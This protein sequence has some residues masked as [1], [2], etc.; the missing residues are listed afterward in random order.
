MI[1][2]LILLAVFM[3]LLPFLL[4]ML[5]TYFLEEEKNNILMNLVSGYI[6]ALGLFE[7]TALPLIAVHQSLSLLMAVYG[8]ILLI[9][10]LVSLCLNFKRIGRVVLESVSAVSGFPLVIWGQ[11]LVILAQ[12]LFYVRYQ[13]TNADD[14]F[15][16]ASAATSVSTNTIFSYNPYTGELYKHLPSRYVLSPFHAF[17]AVV[18]KVVDN[19]PAIIAHSVFMIWFLFIAYM[20]YALIGRKLFAG[21]MEKTGYFLLVLSLLNIFSGYSE[22]TGGLFLL[23]RLWQGKAILAGILLPLVLYMGMR[24]FAKEGKT[25]PMEWLLLFFLMC[26]CCMVSSM[27]IILGAIMLG[28]LGILIFFWKRNIRFLLYAFLCCMPNLICAG[29]YLM[30]R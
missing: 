14:S 24:I 17:I 6:I 30:I 8:G 29:A 4:G 11:I 16:V 18:S 13:Y 23:I 25:P 2:T 26:A 19:H 10:A 20:V 7:I 22:R 28:I 1:K 21:N 9:L 15:F 3:L 12:V 27:G 5:A